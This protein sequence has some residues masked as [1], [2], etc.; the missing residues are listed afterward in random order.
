MKKI[1][2]LTESDLVKLVKRVIKEQQTPAPTPQTQDFQLFGN[3]TAIPAHLLSPIMTISNGTPIL[4][5][6]S[7][8]D[9]GSI[10]P[11]GQ[12]DPMIRKFGM[13]D[14]SWVTNEN[15]EKGTMFDVD[16]QL[17]NKVDIVNRAIVAAPSAQDPNR[18]FCGTQG[19]SSVV[20]KKILYVKILK[21]VRPTSQTQ[22]AN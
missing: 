8:F 16:K 15:I 6:R 18:V 17:K 10:N 7:L 2:R 19:N 21:G 9:L 20:C 3:V 14:T 13:M 22:R 12:N 5:T 11:E 4:R 1:V